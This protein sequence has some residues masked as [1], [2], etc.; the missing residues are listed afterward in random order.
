V[1]YLFSLNA[2]AIDTMLLQ[3]SGPFHPPTYP[4]ANLALAVGA[5]IST[6]PTGGLFSHAQDTAAAAAATNP[7]ACVP[8][9]FVVTC[10]IADQYSCQ[11]RLQ[12]SDCVTRDETTCAEN[13]ECWLGIP[14]PFREECTLVVHE[15]GPD[16]GEF[17]WVDMGASCLA[18]PL[19]G[20]LPS[21][22][23]SDWKSVWVKVT[24]TGER[25][26][27]L[28]DLGDEGNLDAVAIVPLNSGDNSAGIL[29]G[30]CITD[31][32]EMDDVKFFFDSEEGQEYAI[33]IQGEVLGTP[34]FMPS[35]ELQLYP[36]TG[37]AAC[38]RQCRIHT[39]YWSS[40]D[41]SQEL[42]FQPKCT[43]TEEG[44]GA[45]KEGFYRS[46]L[47][48]G[49]DECLPQEPDDLQSEMDLEYYHLAN[50]RVCGRHTVVY[51]YNGQGDP[52]YEEFCITITEGRFQGDTICLQS[53][54]DNP[55]FERCD[56]LGYELV[57]NEQ[58]CPAKREMDSC[59]QSEVVYDC[60]NAGIP[61]VTF[62]DGCPSVDGSAESNGPLPPLSFKTVL[63]VFSADAWYTKFVLGSCAPL[64]VGDSSTGTITVLEPDD[65]V[66]DGSSSSS[67]ARTASCITFL[68]VTAV[69]MVIALL[70]HPLLDGHM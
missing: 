60:S 48:T 70:G 64:E 6:T 26:R 17:Y 13:P 67:A 31:K 4:L 5:L 23:D 1:P 68:W 32:L 35:F 49:C 3:R 66:A 22:T 45:D 12:S 57:I 62:V 25:L 24:G 30:E 27:L 14:S 19:C 41:S 51:L 65:S 44:G 9:P 39:S 18:E 69:C 8:N 50:E 61:T 56:D 36:A 16:T 55:I 54:C 46:T 47:T 28:A 52:A 2:S 34:E 10:E 37:K 63:D 15:L 33:L 58:V 20:A 7:V 38:E 53:N 42:D 21:E 11:E 40:A 59:Q 29:F 43:C